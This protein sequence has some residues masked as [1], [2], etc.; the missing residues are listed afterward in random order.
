MVSLGVVV[1]WLWGGVGGVPGLWRRRNDPP[2]QNQ[3]HGFSRYAHIRPMQDGARERGGGAWGGL[4]WCLG[5]FSL[6]G[7]LRGLGGF[8]GGGAAPDAPTTHLPHTYNPQLAAPARFVRSMV[9]GS[10]LVCYWCIRGVRL[11]V[12]WL[13]LYP[14][15]ILAQSSLHSISTTTALTFYHHRINVLSSP[16]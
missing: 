4:G 9:R 2:L 8:G 13:S 10:F 1:A 11:V 12:L 15:S 5:W 16:H 3:P 6:G 7:L 14:R